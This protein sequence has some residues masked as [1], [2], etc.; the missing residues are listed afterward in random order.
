MSEI[1]AASVYS[2]W[3][4]RMEV[5][6]SPKTVLDNKKK[7]PRKNVLCQNSTCGDGFT[8]WL[9]VKEFFSN[10]E[11]NRLNTIMIGRSIETTNV[12]IIVWF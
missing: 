6:L 2:G 7:K 5:A 1:L 11:R 8:E 9:H 10:E 3:D 4:K 12:V